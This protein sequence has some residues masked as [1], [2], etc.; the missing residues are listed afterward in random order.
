MDAED[1]VPRKNTRRGTRAAEKQSE[2]RWYSNLDRRWSSDLT[3]WGTNWEETAISSKKPRRGTNAS[4]RGDAYFQDESTYSHARHWDSY[5]NEQAMDT[6][7]SARRWWKHR[8]QNKKHANEVVHTTCADHSE[9]WAHQANAVQQAWSYNQ[10]SADSIWMWPGQQNDHVMLAS[11]RQHTVC[12]HNSLASQI[13]EPLAARSLN[14][15]STDMSSIV[16]GAEQDQQP[17]KTRCSTEHAK[18]AKQP[19]MVMQVARRL[20]SIIQS[21]VDAMANGQSCMEFQRSKVST[22][23]IQ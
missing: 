11:E 18:D 21:C 20:M 5:A 4:D 16:A 7:A 10:N 13:N 23:F 12:N 9:L 8:T 15:T 1:K 17:S 19:P 22:R 14:A 2:K 3:T 6:K